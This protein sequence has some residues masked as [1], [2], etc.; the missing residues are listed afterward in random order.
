MK[1]GG[2][3]NKE[4]AR[5]LIVMMAQVE[6]VCEEHKLIPP[7]EVNATDLQGRVWGF[8]YSPEGDS[9]EVLLVAPSLPLTLRLRDAEGSTAEARIS[10]LTLRPVWMKRFLQ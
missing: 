8:D 9:V 6:G 7:I 10:S 2:G 3:M 5:Q 1:N 4:I